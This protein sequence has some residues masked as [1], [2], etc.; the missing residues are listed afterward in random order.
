MS[1]LDVFSNDAFGVISLT[2]AIN[3]L[4]YKPSKLGEMGLFAEE[5]VTTTSVM[6]EEKFGKLSLI[7]AE[8]RGT[9]PTA[10]G[11]TN[12][13]VRSFP[14]TY[15]P[16]V[17]GIE[18]DDVQGMRSF[19]SET[20]LETISEKVNDKLTEMR[21]DVEVTHEYQRIGAIQGIVYDAD[22]SSVLYNWFEEFGIIEH[23]VEFDF[24]DPNSIKLAAANVLRHMQDSLGAET[25][26]GIHC[27]VGAEIM[28]SMMTCDEVKTAYD[29]Y[30]ESAFFREQQARSSFPYAGIMWEEYRGQVGSQKFIADDVARFFP[31]GTKN[32][33]KT[34]F[35]PAPFIE[36]VNTKGKPVYAKQEVR[37]FQTG[38]DLLT[39]SCP[40]VM[41][42]R[43]SVL[44]KGVQA[45]SSS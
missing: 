35:S 6:I 41:C 32:A 13:K 22:G 44:V 17:A 15:L 25:F 3:K 38:V 8:A 36:T 5:G 19:G 28:D 33:F 37:K 45:G 40:L 27:F 42:M 30:Q 34:H 16:V 9:L 7:P 26:K 10:K 14:T 23:E 43:P 24:T 29:R 1:L 31:T 21:Q 18:A 39:V 12:R 20:E 2:T 11:G 4:P